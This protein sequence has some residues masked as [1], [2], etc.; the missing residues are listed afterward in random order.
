MRRFFILS[1]PRSRHPSSHKDLTGPAYKRGGRK[2]DEKRRNQK[3]PE[4]LQSEKLFPWKPG[5]PV[6]VLPYALGFRGLLSVGC[7][8]GILRVVWRVASGSAPQSQPPRGC[9]ARPSV[10][11]LTGCAFPAHLRWLSSAHHAPHTFYPGSSSTF[12]PL[13]GHVFAR[14]T[15]ARQQGSE[16]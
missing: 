6:P 12:P 5:R 2:Q 13:A 8:P 10:S 16:S 7:H 11:P 1:L 9:G 15:L 14:S 4:N 3:S